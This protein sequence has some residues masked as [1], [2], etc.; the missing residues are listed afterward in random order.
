[1]TAS[2]AARLLLL[3][4]SLVLASCAARERAYRT[5]LKLGKPLEFR[6]R[7]PFPKGDVGSNAC[8]QGNYNHV[9]RTNDGQYGQSEV[10][11]CC[12]PVAEILKESFPCGSALPAETLA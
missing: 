2:F 5:D 12:V 10:W 1:M 3:S 11:L 6:P 8:L 9:Y 4:L 7:Y